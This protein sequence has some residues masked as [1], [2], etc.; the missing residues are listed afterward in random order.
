MFMFNLQKVSLKG[1]GVPFHV[2]SSLLLAGMETR[3][4]ELKEPAWTMR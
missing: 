4:L 1:G 3:Y 2:P